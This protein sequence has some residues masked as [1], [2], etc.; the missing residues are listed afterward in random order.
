MLAEV[1]RAWIVKR[2][3]AGLRR[4]RAQGKRIGRPP[5]ITDLGQLRGLLAQGFSFRAAARQLGV[6]DYAV[7]RLVRLH[8]NLAASPTEIC[9]STAP[10]PAPTPCDSTVLATGVG[11]PS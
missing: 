8:P 5:A 4:A 3:H 11:P 6:S 9:N 10:E 7:R 1:E 2:T